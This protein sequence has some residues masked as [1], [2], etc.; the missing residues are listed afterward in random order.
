MT[1]N[2][3]HNRALDAPPMH[4]ILTKGTTMG[5]KSHDTTMFLFLWQQH[6]WSSPISSSSKGKLTEFADISCQFVMAHGDGKTCV[7]S[8]LHMSLDHSLSHY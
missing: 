4:L 1:G 7:C 8:S 5:L 2:V 6:K 3:P